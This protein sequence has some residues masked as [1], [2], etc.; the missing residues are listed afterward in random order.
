MKKILLFL[1]SI[2][3]IISISGCA[4]EVDTNV[5]KV[6]KSSDDIVGRNYQ[7]VISELEKIG[8]TNIETKVL[9]DLIT[10]WLTKDGEIEEVEI[11]GDT[12]FV[13]SDTF[14]KDS[15][16]VITYHTFPIKDENAAEATDGKSSEVAEETNKDVVEDS[17]DEILTVEN[18]AELAAILAETDPGS[19]IVSE[20]AK[21]Y[22]GKI[23]EFDGNIS[24]MIN[25]SNY[26]TRYNI[27]ICA[28]DYS[29]V[30]AI[31]PNF[32]FENVN[33]SD[34]KLTGSEISD[35]IGAGQNL[36][37]TAEVKEYKE[38]SKLFMLRPICT[39]IR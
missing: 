37:I 6:S 39:K 35:S 33:I 13:S 18:N 15:K 2:V 7:T 20:F 4:A 23:I 27:L 1:C 25:N 5:L 32:K 19:L 14:S 12:Q 24:N 10:G 30:T 22:S 34:L 38:N 16:I 9:D 29:E 26:K 36:R 31:G 17:N 3:V 8:F 21:K 11:D 28:G